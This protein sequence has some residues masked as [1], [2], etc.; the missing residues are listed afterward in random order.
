MPSSGETFPCA[1]RSNLKKWLDGQAELPA[2]ITGRNGLLS[3]Q[4]SPKTKRK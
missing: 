1:T 3:P 4:R 2:G